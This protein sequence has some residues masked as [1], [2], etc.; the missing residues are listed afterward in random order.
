MKNLRVKFSVL[1]F[2]ALF[3]AQAQVET[4]G[5]NLQ[6]VNE[7]QDF[8][9]LQMSNL[10]EG[11]VVVEFVNAGNQP[12]IL[13]NVRACCGTRVIDWTK[14]PIMPGGKGTINASFTI[15]ARV[16]NISR[17]ITVFS[18]SINTPNIF[19]IIGNVVE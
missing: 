8:G 7:L 6:F 13:A 2:C 18:N 11:K 15:P 17:T 14:E 4:D 9:T 16:H 19:R 1:L 10:P 12:L 3:V 5:P